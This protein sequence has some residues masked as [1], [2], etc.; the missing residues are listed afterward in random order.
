MVFAFVVVVVVIMFDGAFTTTLLVCLTWTTWGA[1]GNHARGEGGGRI[2]K[3][4]N[5]AVSVCALV[6]II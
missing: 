6:V 5:C 2:L 4:A 3:I 1:F